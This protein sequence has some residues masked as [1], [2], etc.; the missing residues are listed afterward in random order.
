MRTTTRSLA[1][2][3][4]SATC[5]LT[6]AHALHAQTS[7][8]RVVTRDGVLSFALDRSAGSVT[9]HDKLN[10]TTLATVRVCAPAS[11]GTLTADDVSFIVTCARAPA[12]AI[13]SASFAVGEVPT[14]G[15]RTSRRA[16]RGRRNEVIV[17]GT[18]HGEHRTS[19]R[20]GVKVLHDLLREMRPDFVL[21]EIPPNRF[22]LAMAEF[23]RTGTITE[24]RVTR[25]P[26][27][28]DVLFPLTREMTFTIIPTAGWTKPMDTYRNAA[29][30]RLGADSSRRSQ[31][32]AYQAATKTADSLVAA[33][34]SDNPYFIN[35]ALYD[36]LQ[37]LAHDPYNRFFNADLGP[38]GWDN[39]NVTHFGNIAAALDAHRGEGRRFVITYGAGH[40]EWF[41][42]E[43]RR[44]RDITILEVAPFLERI[45][46]TR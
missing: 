1:L 4:L 13:N 32:I 21:T 24:P 26:E 12:M 15:A 35:S 31:W 28:V 19:T 44:R 29:L 17:V 25:F 23:Q 5:G 20:Y 34:G 30:K 36:S 42:R 27:Y 16:T 14:P 10:D 6:M 11:G 18:I 39:I 33:H 22:G 8:A 45:G 3:V 40:K 41:M 2:G 7:S 43:L 37:T 9:V 38:G 46:A